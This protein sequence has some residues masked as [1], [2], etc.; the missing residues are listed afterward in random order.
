[1]FA[2][3]LSGYSLPSEHAPL[4][5]RYR[6]SFGVMMWELC[7]GMLAWDQ[8]GPRRWLWEG[9]GHSTGHSPEEHRHSLGTAAPRSR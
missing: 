8:V 1:M 3:G 2:P 6:Y 7:H 9:E 5:S 4:L